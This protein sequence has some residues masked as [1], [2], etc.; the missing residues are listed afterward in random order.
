MLELEPISLSRVVD[1]LEAAG[2]LERRP[3]PTDRRSKQLFLLP[4]AYPKL[5]ELKAIAA[6][7]KQDA[8]Q[9]VPPAD[10]ARMME[11]LQAMR[12]NL[13]GISSAEQRPDEDTSDG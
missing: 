5:K 13:S 7:A 3:D 11:T 12:E 6:T 10:A 9:G 2:F 1:K 8:L 4:A